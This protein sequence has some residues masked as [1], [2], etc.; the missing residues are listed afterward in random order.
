MWF[1]DMGTSP[2]A[3]EG[4]ARSGTLGKGTFGRVTLWKHQVCFVLKKRQ[5]FC[6]KMIEFYDTPRKHHA[7][8]HDIEY[9][10]FVYKKLRS[11]TCRQSLTFLGYLLPKVSYSF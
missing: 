5:Q 6:F 7:R 4:W 10:A 8:F 3:F 11:G 2:P 9:M 1:G